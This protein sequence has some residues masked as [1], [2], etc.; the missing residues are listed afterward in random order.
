L[1]HWHNQNKLDLNT[2]RRMY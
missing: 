2:K 1:Q